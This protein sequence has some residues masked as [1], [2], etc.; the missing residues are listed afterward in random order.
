M[1]KKI[2]LVLTIV[3]MITACNQGGNGT[4][5]PTPT[6]SKVVLIW[7][8][9]FEP[10]ENV[11]PLIDKYEAEHTNVEIQYEQ[12]GTS[13]GVTGYKSELDAVITDTE[14]NNNPDIFTI[15]NT[16]APKY[17]AFIVKAPASLIPADDLNDFYPI[18]KQ[19]FASNGVLALPIN[20]DSIAMIYNK[21][22]LVESG[23]TNL[24]DDWTQFQEQAKNLTKR[25]ANNRIVSG[26]FSA[27]FPDN[28]EFMF[29]LF[30]LLM[31]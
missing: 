20:M 2:A 6:P 9:M 21:D 14:P 19:N 4:P 17:D 30:N 22:K 26:G 8:N 3:L 28:T 5:T 31:L 11:Q 12:K 10:K 25:D 16:W 29:E 18:I 15:H 13:T 27:G 24:S 23:Y 7:W 1:F